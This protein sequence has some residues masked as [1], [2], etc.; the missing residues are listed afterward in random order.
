VAGVKPKI[1]ARGESIEEGF[2]VKTNLTYVLV[3]MYADDM[4]RP[5][6]WVIFK[7]QDV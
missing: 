6:Q 3:F 2:L 1:A 5:L 4:F 7:S